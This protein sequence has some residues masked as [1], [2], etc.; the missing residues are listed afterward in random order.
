MIWRAVLRTIPA[1]SNP[2]AMKLKL[3]KLPMIFSCF[4]QYS[5]D[6]IVDL[7]TFPMP[8]RCKPGVAG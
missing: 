4:G 8:P 7:S 3:D 1:F 2:D 6:Q 5:L